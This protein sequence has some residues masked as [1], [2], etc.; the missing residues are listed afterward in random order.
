MR[1]RGYL[2]RCV[3]GWCTR[4]GG[5]LLRV[6]ICDLILFADSLVFQEFKWRTMP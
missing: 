6:R 5:A 1:D 4:I 3:Y 2:C